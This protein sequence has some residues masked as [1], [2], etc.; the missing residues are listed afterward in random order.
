MG[1]ETIP[2]VNNYTPSGI[3]IMSS[4]IFPPYEMSTTKGTYYGPYEGV[5]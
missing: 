1:Y 5:I 3:I 4:H 2:T